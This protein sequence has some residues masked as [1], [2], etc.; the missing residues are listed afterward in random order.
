MEKDRI[1]TSCIK[2]THCE[3]NV[4]FDSWGG[5]CCPTWCA[6][7]ASEWSRQS[8]Q[9]LA[10]QHTA[11]RVCVCVCTD[12]TQS[13]KI[14]EC[15]MHGK[16]FLVSVTLLHFFS[17]NWLNLCNRKFY[18]FSSLINRI[19]DSLDWITAKTAS[20]KGVL[21]V[22]CTWGHSCKEPHPWHLELLSICRSHLYKWA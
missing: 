7:S 14:C 20:E 15:A 3:H 11:V 9:R 4:L 8:V 19:C 12:P 22:Q 13:S 18:L 10:W 21:L 5:A 1:V 17:W 2:K 6:Q 16:S